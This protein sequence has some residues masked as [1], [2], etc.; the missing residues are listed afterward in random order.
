MGIPTTRPVTDIKRNA[1]NIIGR[2]RRTR[3]P[4]LVTERG[5]SAAVLMDV[6]SYHFLMRRIEVL[7]AIA[8]GERAFAE[9][10]VV[11]D[12]QARKRLARWLVDS[13]D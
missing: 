7:E 9:R 12:R 1:T 13:E 8:R 10:R 5:H 6:E 2:L 11:S 4:V 3:R